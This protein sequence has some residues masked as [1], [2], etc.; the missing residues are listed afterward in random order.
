MQYLNIYIIDKPNGVINT[1]NIKSFVY[2]SVKNKPKPQRTQS[3][4]QRI[5]KVRNQSS[6]LFSTGPTYVFP[7]VPLQHFADLSP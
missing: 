7:S 4:S 6:F 2:L 1:S 5:T 3:N